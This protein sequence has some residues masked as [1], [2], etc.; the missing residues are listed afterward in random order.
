MISVILPTYNEAL[1]IDSA[2]KDIAQA[3][4]GREHEVIV[5]DDDSP[6]LTWQKAES[7]RVAFPSLRVIRRRNERGLSTAVLTGFA[8]ARGDILVVMDA[9]GQHDAGLL[10]A[11]SALIESD[12]ADIAIASR[13]MTG[14]SVGEWDSYRQSL[15][16]FATRIVVRFCGVKVTDPMSGFFAIRRSSYVAALPH[17]NPKGFKILLDFLLHL[18]KGFKAAEV[19]LQFGMRRAGESK[20]NWKVQWEFLHF[21]YEETLGKIIT[22]LR[23]F[24][25]AA[26]LIAAVLL[27]RIW[28]LLPLY[29]SASTR[30][31]VQHTLQTV[32]SR[33]GWLLS[34]ISL[35]SITQDRMRVLYAP[36]VRGD[37]PAHCFSLSLIT[38]ALEPCDTARL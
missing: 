13:Y 11:L 18:P 29:T 38:S 14:G 21:L 1:T 26:A 32:A 12:A 27:V 24:L 3:L 10:P 30:A 6:D 9:D 17:L 28:P 34:D 20:L 31:A 4:S 7:E 22:P 16:R 8:A 2:L 33:E 23:L 37:D 5:V 36:H 15:S 19:P 35:L 25:V